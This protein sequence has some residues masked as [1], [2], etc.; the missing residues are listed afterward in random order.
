MAINHGFIETRVNGTY[1]HRFRIQDN[2]DGQT[3]SFSA[4]WEQGAK[5]FSLEKQGHD[6]TGT[7]WDKDFST[8]RDNSVQ[9][10]ETGL[11]RAESAAKTKGKVLDTVKPAGPG[12]NKESVSAIRAH[13]QLVAA[14]ATAGAKEGLD[15][16]TKRSIAMSAMSLLVHIGYTDADIKAITKAF[17]A[18]PGSN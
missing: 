5:F 2:T 14:S 16:E 4:H 12:L 9:C 1:T 11:K 6:L 18:K 8:W 10:R 17:L 13:G 15:D 3:Y 7:E